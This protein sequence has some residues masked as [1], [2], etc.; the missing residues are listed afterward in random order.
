MKEKKR[1]PWRIVVGVLAIA[2][3]VYMWAKKDIAA[4][5]STLPP[6]Q[7]LPVLVTTIGVTLVKIGAMAGGILLLRWII[8]KTRQH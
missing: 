6:E 5:Y 8:G 3:I 1:E 7:L 2:F 4:A